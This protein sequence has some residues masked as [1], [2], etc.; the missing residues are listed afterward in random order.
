ME[1]KRGLNVTRALLVLERTILK[2]IGCKCLPSV[3]LVRGGWQGN[4]LKCD[5]GCTRSW[6]LL[7]K[8][9]LLVPAATEQV[10]SGLLLEQRVCRDSPGMLTVAGIVWDNRR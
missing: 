3:S 8:S 7:S 6:A 4:G 5:R 9:A 10:P 2:R 1:C